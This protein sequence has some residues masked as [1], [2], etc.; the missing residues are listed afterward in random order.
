MTGVAYGL[1]F[2][3]M[4]GILG[5]RPGGSSSAFDPGTLFSGDAGGWWDVSDFSTLFQDSA[6]SVP[7]T[8]ADQAVARVEDKSGNGNHLLQATASQ[9][10]VL[11]SGDGGRYCL[12]FDGVDDFLQ[13]SFTLAL[14]VTCIHAIQQLTWTGNDS[15]FDGVTVNSLRLRQT[16]LASPGLWVGNS[17]DGFGTDKMPVGENHVISFV[18]NGASSSLAIDN[19]TP[20]T[21][22]GWSSDAGGFTLGMAGN[23]AGPGNI[24]WFGGIVIGRLLSDTGA[25]SETAKART[26]VGNLA[27]LSL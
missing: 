13:A 20:T 8:G 17:A 6:G 7:V 3:A 26:F 11:S 2:P 25:D 16:V 9:C 22:L 27:G 15:I 1:A 23:G 21:G 10:P 19:L 4:R 12:E 18:S 14:P 5:R 24:L